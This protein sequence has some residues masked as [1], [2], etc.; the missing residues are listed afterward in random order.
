MNKI[1]SDYIKYNFIFPEGT[2]HSSYIY[3]KVFRSIYGY[4]QNVTKKNNKIYTYLRKGIISEIP[5]IKPGKNTVILPLN[6]KDLLL[7]YF[8]T[9]INPTHNWKIRGDWKVDYNIDTIEVDS[10]SIIRSLEYYI[11]NYKVINIFNKNNLLLN[12]I[13]FCI[14]NN[15]IN[16]DYIDY[17]YKIINKITSFNW[18][19]EVYNDSEY[20]TNF[21][22]KVI[23]FKNKFYNNE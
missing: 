11:K 14:N 16:K 4:S 13:E 17:I 15:N 19:K 10:E 12:E 6:N 20:L 5:Y 1:K 18:Y 23:E 7:D 21:N 8:K 9:G 2:N 3:Q 22:N